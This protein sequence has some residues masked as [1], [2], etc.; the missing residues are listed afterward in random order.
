MA[1]QNAKIRHQIRLRNDKF[2][3]GNFFTK[4]NEITEHF[5]TEHS[6]ARNITR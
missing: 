3:E 2:K 1:S 5:G 6:Y 4:V